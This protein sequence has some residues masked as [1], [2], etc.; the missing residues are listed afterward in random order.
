M[1]ISN[2]VWKDYNMTVN[3]KLYKDIVWWY[4]QTTIESGL[5]AGLVCFYNEKVDL[6]VD[7]IKEKK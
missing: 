3:G 6:Y 7:D 2:R 1:Q 5:V 4:P